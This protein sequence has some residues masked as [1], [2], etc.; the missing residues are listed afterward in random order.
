MTQPTPYLPVEP[1]NSNEPPD[2]WD[3]APASTPDEAAT[4]RKAYVVSMRN[5]HARRG[6][7]QSKYNSKPCWDGGTDPRT[8]RR[9]RAVWPQIVDLAKSQG[10]DALTLLI[11]LFA[12]W[13][14]DTGPTPWMIVAPEHVA[15]CVANRTGRREKAA[16][17][18]RADELGFR[19]AVWA[20]SQTIP[21]R[22]RAERF[23]LN[24]LSRPI[25]PLFRVCVATLRGMADVVE[26]WSYAARLQFAKAPDAYADLWASLL[27]KAYAKTV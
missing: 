10:F 9:Y 2:D 12:T 4:L 8:G 24:D 5:L 23:V 25:T 26:R 1:V 3:E 17:E 13:P 15:R 21:D 16:S 18:L 14:S 22:D 27:P 6:H 11:E 20:A 7:Y 19:T